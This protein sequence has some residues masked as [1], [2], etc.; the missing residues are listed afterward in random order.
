MS[1]N[2]INLTKVTLKIYNDNIYDDILIS[3]FDDTTL[4][5]KV[6]MQYAYSIYNDHENKDT[7]TYIN[8]IYDVSVDKDRVAFRCNKNI[9]HS[10]VSVEFTSDEPDKIEQDKKDA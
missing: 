8:H 5:K 3:I 2:K 7:D 6:K 4:L 10:E 1:E 9:P